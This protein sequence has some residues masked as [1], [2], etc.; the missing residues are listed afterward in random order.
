M[1]HTCT[2]F[3]CAGMLTL[4]GS[5]RGAA[6]PVVTLDS[7]LDEMVD[8][9][10]AARWPVPE[11]KCLQASSHDRA[12]VSPGQ[13]GWFANNDHT[14]YLRTE[15]VGGRKEHVMMDARGPGCIVRFWLTTVTNKTGTLRIYLDGHP[16]PALVFPA[17][18][19]LSGDLELGEPFALPHPGYKADGNGGNTLML[20][21]PYAEQCKVTWQE[22]GEGPRYYQ[23]NHRSYPAGT[24]VVS[25]T[26]EALEAARPKLERTG[27]TLLAPPEPNGSDCFFSEPL[28]GGQQ[29]VIDLPQGP[30]AIRTLEI[31]METRDAPPIEQALRSM[32]VR[33]QFDNEETAWC[34]AGDF[35]GSG[36]G[37][38]PLKSWYRDV[39]PDGT[40]RCRWVMPYA[41]T[42][43][44][45]LSN[46]GK[47]TLKPALRVTTT[48]WEWND[49]S[50]HFHTA[51]HSESWLTT[52]PAR[53]WNFV[54]LTGRGVYVGDTLSLFNPIATWY[55][56]GDEKIRVDG[57]TLPSHLGTGTEDYYNYSFAPRGIFQTP[58]ANQTRVDE[59]STR[60]HNVL[61]RSRNL[62]G[63]PFRKSL[64][65][66]MELMSWN[67]TRLSYAATTHWYAFPGGRS[68]ISPQPLAAAGPLP[69]LTN[70]LSV[71]RLPGW[72]ECETL[73]PTASSP[74]LVVEAQ[75]MDA[76]GAIR[77][78]GGSQLLAKSKDVGDFL[79]L[80]VPS[81]D[82][83]PRNLTLL[84]SQAPDYGILRITVNGQTT[85]KTFDGYAPDVRPAQPFAL[86][87][88]KPRNGRF[89]LRI[90]VTGTNP[91]AAGDR[92]YLGLDGIAVGEP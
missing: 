85:G 31:R 12:T 61:T 15:D 30:A 74:G 2:A 69:E 42:G 3:I 24:P 55:G 9:G 46:L 10:S 48:P 73:R 19:L 34:P 41:K 35:F 76:F 40:M 29:A 70:I 83:A 49:R 25:F 6:S 91:A 43:R 47:A 88:F 81:P 62:D 32:I 79:E 5:L 33:L 56:E 7:L 63:I 44:I 4:L 82:A 90:E 89:I 11:F 21:I 22:A 68:N 17:Y 84:A 59:P 86:G 71:P 37:V 16:E 57:E 39:L 52:P 64:D 23:I 13:A 50:M 80:A 67:P 66:D 38:N 78:S 45:I 60:G 51:W 8:C 87:V 72:V 54:S 36:V 1:I 26:R 18:D 28:Q 58:F 20:P 75:A 77:W 65:F 27:K 53:D 14:Q 92:Y